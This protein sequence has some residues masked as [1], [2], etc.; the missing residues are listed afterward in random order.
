MEIHKFIYE[1]LIVDKINYMKNKIIMLKFIKFLSIM[2]ASLCTLSPFPVMSETVHNFPYYTIDNERFVFSDDLKTTPP[3]GFI[4]LNFTSI[5]CLPC[6]KEIPELL[7]LQNRQGDCVRLIFFYT[8]Y[9]SVAVKNDSALKGITADS[10]RRICIDLFGTL[11]REF[12]VRSLPFT[13]VING[14]GVVVKK[15]EG[16]KQQNIREINTI[17]EEFRN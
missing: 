10:S 17:I 15:F 12:G 1:H 2:F 16:Y 6:K 4:I 14:R 13:M 5:H 7:S 8:D 9:D 11:Q 3:H